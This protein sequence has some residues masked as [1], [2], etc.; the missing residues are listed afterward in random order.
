MV[1]IKGVGMTRFGKNEH[2]LIEMMVDAA[3]LACLD[4]GIEPEAF[5]EVLVGVIAPEEFTGQGNIAA[6]FADAFAKQ[7]NTAPIEATRLETASST[8]AALMKMGY[9]IA[10]TE[11]KPLL[12]VAGEKMKPKENSTEAT[13]IISRVIDAESRRKDYTMPKLAAKITQELLQKTDVKLHDLDMIGL[14][15]HYNGS[16]NQRAHF[17]DQVTLEKVAE[18]RYVEDPLRLYHCAPISD[19]AA[20][21][22]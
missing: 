16:F 17:Q 19:G 13:S 22:V 3:K 1:S 2:S 20:A 12:L 6:V 9:K 15:N 5:S 4:A 21:V 11:K 8:G 18:S 10:A 7:T 14:K